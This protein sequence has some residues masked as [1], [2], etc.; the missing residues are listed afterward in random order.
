MAPRAMIF[1]QVRVV[2]PRKRFSSGAGVAAAAPSARTWVD[3]RWRRVAGALG[4][5]ASTEGV[6]DEAT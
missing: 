5:R 2:S 3:R 4:F 6:K 1:C